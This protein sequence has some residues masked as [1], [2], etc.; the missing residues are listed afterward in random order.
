[1]Y[2]PFNHPEV[3][4]ARNS[5]VEPGKLEST[6]SGAFSEGSPA[7]TLDPRIEELER[8]IAE[9]NGRVAES[10]A[11][12]FDGV[13]L[14]QQSD[15]IAQLQRLVANLAERVTAGQAATARDEQFRA[16]ALSVEAAAAAVQQ[17]A[18]HPAVEVGQVPREGDCG[19]GPCQCVSCACCSFEVWMT[20]VRVD[21]MQNLLDF[22]PLSAD[23]NALPYGMMEVW[24]FASID[25]MHNIGRCIPDPSPTSY[26][27]LHKQITDPYGPWV[28]VNCCVGTVTVRK[29]V[30][31]TVPLSLT[32]VEREDAAE[33]AQPMNRDEW[34]SATQDI[35]LDCCCASYPPI[36]ISVSLTSWGQAGGAVTGQFLIRKT[37]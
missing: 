3:K 29:G 1:V 20:H 32:V 2:V 19:C 16:A 11:A 4:M 13:L 8:R 26:L 6:G 14:Q 10:T 7:Q 36:R 23:S 24:M 12:S 21:Q 30:P 25:P 5:H 27:P 37:C 35:T 31:L 9:L 22:I 28:S 18:V 15:Q 17:S 33:R 34:G